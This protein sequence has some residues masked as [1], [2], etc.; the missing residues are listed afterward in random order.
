MNMLNKKKVIRFTRYIKNQAIKEVRDIDTYFSIGIDE[1]EKDM[2]K[3]DGDPKGAVFPSL[4]CGFLLIQDEQ[5]EKK[6][7]RVMMRL[8]N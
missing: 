8:F 3:D 1:R 6:C 4:M 7:L 5:L 2:N